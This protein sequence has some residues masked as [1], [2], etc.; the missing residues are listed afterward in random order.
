MSNRLRVM[1][2]RRARSLRSKIV[3]YAN[4]FN[5]KYKIFQLKL[6]QNFPPA[7]NDIKPR[8][9]HIGPEN[10][11]RVQT[12]ELLR[13]ERRISQSKVPKPPKFQRPIFFN[14]GLY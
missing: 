6:D 11:T 10:E 13:I 12:G 4:L 3:E 5:L 2:K 1:R 7:R 9:L 8:I 14:P